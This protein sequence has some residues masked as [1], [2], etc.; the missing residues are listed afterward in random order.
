MQTIKVSIASRILL[1][2][3]TCVF[4]TIIISLLYIVLNH[5]INLSLLYLAICAKAFS[6]PAPKSVSLAVLPSTLLAV[7]TLTILHIPAVCVSTQET[8]AVKSHCLFKSTH[9]QFKKILWLQ[10]R[11]HCPL[12]RGS[13]GLFE[14]PYCLEKVS[15][16]GEPTVKAAV[17][18]DRGCVPSFGVN[19]LADTSSGC[20]GVWWQVR[21][22]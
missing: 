1:Q 9:A 2:S 5:I 6:C 12:Y 21:N 18:G 4:R 15:F 3:R 22:S 8:M 7:A 16:V 11:T 13:L 10:P 17:P 20:A 14:S 19:S